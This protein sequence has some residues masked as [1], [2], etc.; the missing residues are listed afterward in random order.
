MQVAAPDDP[1][2]IREKYE[3]LKYRYG[4]QE[5]EKNDLKKRVSELEG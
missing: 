3:S 1:K 5:E 4:K 2:V